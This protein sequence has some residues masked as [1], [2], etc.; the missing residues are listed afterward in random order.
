MELFEKQEYT[1]N[2]TMISILSKK[3]KKEHGME[4]ERTRSVFEKVVAAAVCFA[5]FRKQ[6]NITNLNKKN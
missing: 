3:K 1:L 5:R 6:S 2:K 4:R